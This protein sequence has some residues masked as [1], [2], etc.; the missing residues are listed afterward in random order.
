MILYT[1]AD[2]KIIPEETCFVSK[3]NIKECLKLLKLKNIERY[4][5]IPQRLLKEGFDHLILPY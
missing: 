3:E 5:R 1:R 4:D 2:K